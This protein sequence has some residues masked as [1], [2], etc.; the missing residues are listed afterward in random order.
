MPLSIYQCIYYGDVECYPQVIQHCYRF[1]GIS[2]YRMSIS[3]EDKVNALFVTLIYSR[4]EAAV[5][6]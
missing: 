5:Q 2:L 6:S 1:Y 4:D 3:S